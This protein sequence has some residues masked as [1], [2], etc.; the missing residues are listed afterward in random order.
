MRMKHLLALLISISSFAVIILFPESKPVI[1][2]FTFVM[3]MSFFY[4]LMKR[5]E[6]RSGKKISL[7]FNVIKED[8]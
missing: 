6:K 2:I 5:E 1:N 3:A 7:Y 8:E 4:F